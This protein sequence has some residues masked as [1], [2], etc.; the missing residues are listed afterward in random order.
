[1]IQTPAKMAAW[2]DVFVGF[3]HDDGMTPQQGVDKLIAATK[4][5]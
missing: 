3:W 1:M 4:A 5:N 2:R